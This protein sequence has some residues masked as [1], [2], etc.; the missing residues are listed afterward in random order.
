MHNNV[1]I[2]EKEEF[3]ANHLLLPPA[4]TSSCAPCRTSDWAGLAQ[5]CLQVRMG[6]PRFQWNLKMPMLDEPGRIPGMYAAA[7]LLHR[8]KLRK[9]T[10]TTQQ[11]HHSI[12]SPCIQPFISKTSRKELQSSFSSRPRSSLHK[13][14]K[15]HAKKNMTTQE[16]NDFFRRMAS[17]H[18]PYADVD[19]SS[20]RA[21]FDKSSSHHIHKLVQHPWAS[22]SSSSS[23]VGS[24]SSELLTA[25]KQR[26]LYTCGKA[27]KL[28]QSLE[29]RPSHT[30]LATGA[31]PCRSCGKRVPA[32]TV[33][34][35]VKWWQL[36]WP[37]E[38]L[39][40]LGVDPKSSCQAPWSFPWSSLQNTCTLKAKASF[41]YYLAW[42][43]RM[44][45][46]PWWIQNCEAGLS[47]L[48]KFLDLL[49]LL[50]HIHTWV[51]WTKA[52]AW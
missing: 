7:K 18:L 4:E 1:A 21:H 15:D 12:L 22:L 38:R 45:N 16:T 25:N 17:S 28:C 42:A 30:C 20:P 50:S 34:N 36:D 46:Q 32:S 3:A 19:L 10:K 39:G 51:T 11:L 47:H 9:H 31:I 40:P 33:W 49:T 52:I 6:N 26:S 2:V 13:F 23:A 14:T 5:L 8:W 35:T 29:T 27:G 37:W 43:S 41:L 48:V 44:V 24:I